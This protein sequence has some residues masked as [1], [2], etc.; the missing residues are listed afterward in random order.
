MAVYFVVNC[1]IRDR[2]LLDEYLA[3]AGASESPVP[4][5]VLAMDDQSDTIEGTPAGSRTVLLEFASKDD[6][7][8]WYESPG[9][10]AVIAK[11]LAATEGFAVLVQGF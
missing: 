6:F 4:V 8:A 9:Y 3:G 10:Q 5:K 1:S 7:R 2:A 11:R